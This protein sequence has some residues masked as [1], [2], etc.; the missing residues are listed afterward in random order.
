MAAPRLFLVDSFNFIFRAFHARQ[1]TGAPPM[2]TSRG[3]STE[4]VYIFHNM[5]RR[6]QNTYKPDYFAAVFESMGPTFRDAVFP[7]YKANRTE[8][9]PEL[10]E[11]IPLVE[12]LLN[13]QRIPVLQLPGYEAD[14]II[15]TV[16]ARTAGTGIELIIVSSDKDM[17]QLVNEHVRMLNPMK[18]DTIYGAAEVLEFMGVP[19]E[20]VVD[21]L[22]LKG[23]SV[24][25]IPGAPG[26]GDK[27]ARDLIVQYG[28]VESVLEHAAEIPR[29]T[30]RESLLNHRDQ[31]L[32]S[33]QLATIAKD[34]PL[35]IDLNDLA[36][37]VPDR[38]ALSA[39]YRDLEFYSFLKD[40]EP[41]SQPVTRTER[42][43]SSID[44]VP[45]ADAAAL[46]LDPP[47]DG[48][49]GTG[50]L[51]L[52]ISETECF[53]LP[54][55]MRPALKY[56][57]LAVYDWKTHLLAGDLDSA[58]KT[59]DDVLLY[60]FLLLSDPSACALDSLVARYLDRKLEGSPAQAA[61]A[62]YD[63]A[64]KL[65]PQ[66]E[67]TPFAEVYRTIDL[68]LAPVLA[69]MERTG[70]RVDTAYMRSLGTGMESEIDRLAHE[71][72]GL[73]GHPFN[74]N[75]PPQL[76][77]V[78]FE[79][80]KIP[81]MGKTGKT[82]SYSTAADVL[83]ALATDYPIAA[84]VLEYR[85][86]AKLKGTYVDALPE[87]I[88]PFSGRV[89]TTF[90]AAGAATGRLSS[91]NP[92]LQNIPI[93]TPL[94]R[95]IRA[96]FIPE[97][98]W[99]LVSADYSQIELRLLAHFSGDRVLTDSFRKGE[100]IHTRTAAEV[101]GVP[102]LMVT[103]EL[104][105][106]AKAVNFGIVYGQTPFGLA[107]QL[108]ISRSEADQYI[109]S[110]FERYSGVKRWIDATIS[111]VRKDGF[112]R[113]FHGRQRTIPDINARHPSARSFAERTAVNTPLQG[114]AAD[115]IKIAMIEI[116]RDLIDQKMRTRMLLQ[117]HDE[118]VLE[119]PP[120][121]LDAARKLVKQ[122][123]ENVIRLDV[124]LLVETGAGPNWRDAK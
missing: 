74:I 76:G 20:R 37:K 61:A 40:L 65:L 30:Y 107:A 117:V 8:T 24:D 108:G 9:P 28:S 100:D 82:R 38:D 88:R 21:L 39:I 122:R 80:M 49:F 51:G 52:C 112:T 93:R 81:A 77:K 34:A 111:Q 91:S 68:P 109:R 92:N 110:Y 59:I 29:K 55:D 94:G 67:N 12:K 33:K 23:D 15:G 95:D 47:E 97:P 16:A 73:A 71:I 10:L 72:Y 19:P 120:D 1:R 89:H 46:V 102:P 17:L 60:A 56:R 43:I 42:D 118:L 87:L 69:R 105:R 101:F 41:A 54:W 63:L 6:L 5:I 11:Q 14:D 31:V 35:E 104:R 115:L 53:T 98:G 3:N 121:E 113:T 84:K 32:L 116:D 114:T 119:S 27:G 13:A 78:L 57:S 96:A 18:D 64:H 36:I 25:N 124:P 70:I 123:M 85:Q 44:N 7:A 90:N 58:P 99:V 79:E 66:I 83:E 45:L 62:I 26:I 48:T 2:R 106:N 50:A 22:A 4:A 103:P 75:S 86:L